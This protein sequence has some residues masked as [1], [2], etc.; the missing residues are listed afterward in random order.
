M[1]AGLEAANGVLGVHAVGQHD[2]NDVDVGIVLQLVVVLVAVDILRVDAIT[3]PELGG[4]FGMSGNEGDRLGMLAQGK[5]RK[6]LVDG[7]RTESDDRIAE[8][9]ARRIGH[10]QLRRRRLQQPGRKAGGRN[11]L[12]NTR[13]KAPPSEFVIRHG[14]TSL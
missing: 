12:S 2:V 7:E 6:D 4:L 10:A 9:L 5:R 8:L 3:R 11:T 14:I 13:E 1:L